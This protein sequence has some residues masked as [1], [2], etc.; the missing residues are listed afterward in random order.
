MLLFKINHL[1]ANTSVHEQPGAVVL[2]PTIFNFCQ[3][4]FNWRLGDRCWWLNSAQLHSQPLSEWSSPLLLTEKP[5]QHEAI[6]W[7][8]AS[9]IC[10]REVP[11]NDIQ[12]ERTLCQPD[13]SRGEG[14]QRLE[15]KRVTQRERWNVARE[16]DIGGRGGILDGMCVHLS[17]GHGERGEKRV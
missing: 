15:K 10:A 3:C 7:K 9:K 14:G 8:A 16:K 6:G 17:V 12:Q 4:T 11:G 13:C 1:S 2:G 5:R